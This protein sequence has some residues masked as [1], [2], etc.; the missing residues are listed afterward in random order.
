MSALPHLHDS[1]PD[2]GQRAVKMD[3]S[4]FSLSYPHFDEDDFEYTREIFAD[5]NIMPLS[6]FRLTWQD[7]NGWEYIYDAKKSMPFFC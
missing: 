4:T 6:A 1:D 7:V 3:G 2:M 5:D